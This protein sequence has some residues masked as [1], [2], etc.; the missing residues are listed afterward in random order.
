MSGYFDDVKPGDISGGTYVTKDS[1]KRAEYKTGMV[2]DTTE[3]KARFDLLLPWGVPYNEQML[4]RWAAL[5]ARGAVKYE[6]RNWEKARTDE[7]LRRFMSSAFR[8]FMQW[9]AGE[10]DE[11]H[12]A[13]VLFNI[14][15]AEFVLYHM[16]NVDQVEVTTLADAEPVYIEGQRN[17]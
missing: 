7:E 5:M 13:A 16:R 1:G 6:D 2:R 10:D 3:G 11:D 4:T 14:M 17:R 15:G 8:H 9:Q 12:A